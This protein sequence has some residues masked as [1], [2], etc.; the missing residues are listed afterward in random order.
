V[1]SSGGSGLETDPIPPAALFGLVAGALA[2]IYPYFDG[3]A[4]AL[5]A[6][7]LLSW[8]VRRPAP[9]IVRGLGLPPRAVALLAVAAGWGL[10]LLDPPHLEAARGLVLSVG[11]L[12]LWLWFRIDPVPI[13]QGAP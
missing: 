6:L 5:A 4:V 13:V 11:G 9:S 12:P 7:L 3:L 1:S 10:F 2:V 8:I